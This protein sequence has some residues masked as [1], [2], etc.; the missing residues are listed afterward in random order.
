[1]VFERLASNILIG[2]EEGRIHPYWHLDSNLDIREMLKDRLDA[3]AYLARYGRHDVFD[4]SRPVPD[5]VAAVRAIEKIVRRENE[6]TTS[7]ENT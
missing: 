7:Q 4:T 1:M 2:D 6:I 3:R 5:M